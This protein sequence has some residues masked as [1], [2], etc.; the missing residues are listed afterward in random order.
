MAASLIPSVHTVL[1][2]TSDVG[3][4]S[5]SIV[6]KDKTNDNIDNSTLAAVS[7]LFE[8]STD[9]VL[10]TPATDTDIISNYVLH[11]LRAGKFPV[12][13]MKFGGVTLNVQDLGGCNQSTPIALMGERDCLTLRNVEG[14]SRNPDDASLCIGPNKHLTAY[15]H[16]TV[17][18][19]M[20]CT[21]VPV[22]PC[23]SDSAG[24]FDFYCV[25]P[26]FTFLD[27][28]LRLVWTIASLPRLCPLAPTPSTA[29]TTTPFL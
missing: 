23:K 22:M 6:R 26:E 18:P 11:D 19:T 27:R 14:D 21:V 13:V 10:A 1:L 2:V 20:A 8:H 29:P 7:T 12:N 28:M 5:V 17:V 15:V 9:N 25:L 3:S 4:I 24:T 16:D